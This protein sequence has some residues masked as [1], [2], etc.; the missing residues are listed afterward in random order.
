MT[1]PLLPVY[2]NGEIVP[3]DQARIS[4]FDRGFMRGDG[5]FE[6]MRAYGGQVFR[7]QDHLARLDHGLKA[8][9]FP[10]RSADLN[11]EA[12]IE[13][14]IKASGLTSA[15]L[16]V[17]VTRGVGTTEFTGQTGASPTV[18]VAVQP[19]ADTPVAPLNVIVSTI[20]RDENSPLAEI[21]TIN[22]VPSILARIEAEAAGAD[23]AIML[24][25]AGFVAEGCASNVFLVHSGM[26]FTPDLASGVLP[27]I[28]R[29]VVLEIASDLDIPAR[30]KLISP[31]LLESADEIFLAS[32]T[33]EIVPVAT[34]DGKQVGAGKY[35]TAER[36]L[37][38]YRKR[39]HR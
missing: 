25:Y 1:M 7:L 34:L 39:A 2:V 36:L 17:E 8:L 15:R 28:T 12:A 4:V 33:R 5:V 16:R 37:Q 6:T 30:E 27:G 29:R 26:L 22:Y 18:V 38:E 31:G 32:S 3:A 13:A 24:N 35:D 9:R 20:R 19:I 14:T 23:D 10:A 21:K 11:L